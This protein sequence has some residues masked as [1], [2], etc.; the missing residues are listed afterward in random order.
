MAQSL[1]IKDTSAERNRFSR[2]ALT[3][4]VLVLGAMALLFGRMVQLQVVEH[5]TYKTRSEDN[6]IQLQPIPPPRGLIYDRHGVLLAD[7]QGVASLSI[8]KERA[9][10]LEAT[11]D[12]LATLVPVSD[13]ELA[14]F[15]KRLDQRRRPLQPVALKVTLN[16]EEQAVLA[17]NR[18]DLP[19][20]QV[21][22]Q[23]LRHY[24]FGE[25]FAHVVGSVRRVNESDLQRLDS[26]RYSGTNFVGKRG[27]ESFYENSLH[28]QVG[29]RKVEID[30][31][32]RIRRVVD[33][34]PPTAG[35]NITTHLDSRLQIAASAALG[36]RRGAIVAINPKTGGILAMV[37]QPGYDPNSFVTGIGSAEY[38][39]LVTSLNVPLFDRATRGQYAPGSTFKPIVGLAA[40]SYGKTHWQDTIEDRGFF[41]LPGQE[42]IYR[43]WNWTA[44]NAGGQGTVDLRRAIYRSSNVYF[45]DLGSRLTI[46]EI[47]EFASQFGY[48]SVTSIDVADA[49]PGLLPDPAWKYGAKG[50]PWYP[51]DNINL[52]I[53]QGDLLVTPLQV[54]TVATLIANR[55]HWVRPRLMLSSDAPL[56]DYDPPARLGQVVGPSPQDWENIVDA[57]E[58]VV[59][60]GNKGYGNNG[61]AWAYVGM[62]IAYRMAGKSGTAQVVEIRQ[63]E[64]YDEELLDEYN[65]KHA[66]FM[67][68]APADD[69]TIALAVLVENG[70][71]GSS[72]AA[73]VAKEV[74]DAYL[75]PQLAER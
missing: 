1:A 43:D 39:E 29:Y 40:L 20:V 11:L 52:S 75:L 18:H 34:Q 31:R 62:D 7:N 41:Q 53:G 50:E 61:T 21:D 30:A 38:K 12:R 6:R 27:L 24:P 23:L 33:E 26:V 25:L 68:F 69:P 45:Y 36:D 60:R 66:W 35:M 16:E 51:G 4:Y 13:D 28:G 70:G 49:Q 72:V 22:T 32:G 2:R 57:M 15:R 42:R 47:H 65:R 19:G 64:E 48:G 17:V 10:D 8:V 44:R 5:E 73:P 14:S 67:A 59:H 46:D 37:S 58:E 63:G 56:L 71:G 3:L 55:G 54:A 9:G 74:V